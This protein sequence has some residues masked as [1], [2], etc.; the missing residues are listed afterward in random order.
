MHPEK[1]STEGRANDAA[2]H[3]SSARGRSP[4][5]ALAR[6]GAALAERI[7]L[8][9]AA[10][11]VLT[12][13]AGALLAQHI[14]QRSAEQQIQRLAREL[15]ATVAATLSHAAAA[16]DAALSAMAAPPP[17]DGAF[18]VR[19]TAPNG[20]V[21]LAIP[22]AAADAQPGPPL[23]RAKVERAS[24]GDAGEVAVWRAPGAASASAS[25]WGPW[26]LLMLSALVAFLLA[27]RLVARRL[28]SVTAIERN[29]EAYSAGL[30]REL[31]VLMLGAQ[32]GETARAWNGLITELAALKEQHDAQ[33]TDAGHDV[34]L[35][36][37]AR[38]LR[39]LLD[40]LPFGVMRIA[41]DGT[42]AYAN[43]AAS[44]MVGG[45]A[46]VVGAPA[47]GILHDPTLSRALAAPQNLPTGVLSV[48]PP[49]SAGENE[50]LHRFTVVPLE[51]RGEA[52][53]AI[54]DIR[55][56][57][58]AERARDNFLYHVTHELRTPLTNIHAYAETLTKPDF[59]DEQTRK[60]CYNVIISETRRLSRLVEDI[61]SVSQLEVGSA[62]VDFGEVDLV[63]LLR[64][65]VQDNLGRADEKGIDLTLKVPPKVPKMRG[66]K[67]RLSV[68]INN[69]IGNAVK[70][71]PEKGWVQVSLE[72]DEQSVRISVA[73]S[74][75]GIAV[76]DQPHVFEKFYRAASAAV[77]DVPGTGLG[78]AIAREVARLHGGDIRLESE[79]G[80]G[81]TFT[82]ELPVGA[83]SS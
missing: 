37:E 7:G 68:L 28:R 52:L 21:R 17:A 6:H 30:E 80:R 47:A 13:I 69:L 45:G 41:Q 33:H 10:L 42:V 74:G 81:S 66:D 54:Q 16:D 11:L 9:F 4:A 2:Q 35:K 53:V 67:Q 34:L 58:E 83:S 27:Y 49:A 48:D 57:R 18:M 8:G 77:Q 75:C 70:Y 50:S 36:F 73:D 15:A 31:R 40:R 61:L 19:W 82:V 24:G 79:P 1:P 76:E 46:K 38:S 39:Q 72:V 26:W 64:Q 44:E 63:R 3:T 14:A 62:C 56:L 71:T 78:L 43:P 25:V 23:A 65:M 5:T 51:A 29:L 60:E 20:S 59:D 55:H 12:L 22:A 32:L